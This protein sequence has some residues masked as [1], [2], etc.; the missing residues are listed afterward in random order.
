MRDMRDMRDSRG[1]LRDSRS[2]MRDSRGDMRDSREMNGNTAQ[3]VTSITD[4]QTMLSR[5]W[6]AHS[7]QFKGMQSPSFP[8]EKKKA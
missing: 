3:E 5:F 8:A 6:D 7:R 4:L 2:D 1:D